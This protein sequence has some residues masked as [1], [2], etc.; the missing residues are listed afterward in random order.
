MLIY[1]QIP[2]SIIGLQTCMIKKI[3]SLVGIHY[4][5]ESNGAALLRY[6]SDRHEFLDLD[7][8]KL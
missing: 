8:D 2:D 6:L 7:L 4:H 5:F 1:L 3:Q